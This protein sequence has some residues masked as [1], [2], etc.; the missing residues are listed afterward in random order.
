MAAVNTTL[1]HLAASL[2]MAGTCLGPATAAPASAWAQAR[3]FVLARCLIDRY[4]GT[5]LG[6][7]AEAWAGG[8]VERGSLPVAAY[9]RLS[10]LVAKAPAPGT[11]PSGAVMRLAN[12]VDFHNDP[13][14][15]RRIRQILAK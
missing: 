15:Q 13:H 4:A 5:P 12:C 3:D 11:T 1:R 9:A 6:Q 10:A 2:A 14:L 7:E 8:I